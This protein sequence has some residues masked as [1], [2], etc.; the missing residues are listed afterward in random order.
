MKKIILLLLLTAVGVSA[1]SALRAY[2]TNGAITWVRVTPD[3]YLLATQSGSTN[4]YALADTSVADTTT[5]SFGFTS[6]K[7]GINNDETG[8]V[9]DSTTLRISTTNAFGLNTTYLLYAGESLS[10]DYATTAVYIKWGKTTLYAN[11][12]SRFIVN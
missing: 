12:K 4:F 5:I 11:K 2:D 10:L 1:Q 7:I 6:K 9:V 3:G 8:G